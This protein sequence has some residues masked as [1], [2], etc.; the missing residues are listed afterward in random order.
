GNGIQPPE[1][2]IPT[3]TVPPYIGIGA[4]EYVVDVT[5]TVE[6]PDGRQVPAIDFISTVDTSPIAELN[7][8]Y[9]TL[10]CGYRTRASGETDFP[11]IYGEDRKSTRLNSS[12][13]GISYAVFC[14]KKKKN[15]IRP[16]CVEEILND[17]CA[18][19][20]RR[21]K[22]QMHEH[23]S[24]SVVHCIARSAF[25]PEWLLHSHNPLAL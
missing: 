20:V 2:A 24:R 3:Y 11:C 12:H 22:L 25:V 18:S 4:N 19:L 10:N 14:L 23:A 8:W 17:P 15:K 9:H 7:M 16:A 1:A 13:L 21:M 6:G 5:H